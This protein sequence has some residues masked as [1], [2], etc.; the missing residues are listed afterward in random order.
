[1]P[2]LRRAVLFLF[3]CQ[4]TAGV[5]ADS[6][7]HR[8]LYLAS[9]DGAQTATSSGKG[10]LVFDIDAD[11]RFVRRIAN[12]NFFS[13]VRGLTGCQATHSLYYS[14]T[15]RHLGRFD[16]ETGEVVW[17]RQYSGGCDRSS[18]TLDGRKVFAPTGWWEAS[19]NGGFVVID[20]MTGDELRRI[21]VGTGAHNSIVSLDGKRLYLGT[22]TTLTVFNPEDES[23]IRQ[24]PDVGEYGVFPFTIDHRQRH[25]F[26]CLALQRQI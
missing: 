4:L 15:T 26:V 12:T 2:L 18:V 16:L 24:I 5:R 23:V 20:G 7:V 8:Y 3:L 6:A 22:T 17:D 13:G 19:D 21:K 25:A 1:M 10:L 9:P 11:F 14:T